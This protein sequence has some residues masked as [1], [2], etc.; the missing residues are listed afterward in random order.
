M[1]RAERRRK[2]KDDERL[3]KEG[4]DAQSSDPAGT[5]AMMRLMSELLEAA[6]HERN[7]DPP[8]R[9][10]H[11]KVDA[12]LHAMR[13]QR[14]DCKKGCAHC[15][16]VWVSATI[17]EV[18]FVAKGMRRRNDAIATERV[19][20]AH[21]ITGA[22]NFTTRQRL[23]QQ[24]PLLAD[25]LCSV[26][27]TRPVSCRF[28]ASTNV[29]ACLRVFRQSSGE[30][31]PTPLNNLK[32]RGAYEIALSLALKHVGLPHYYYELNAALSRALERDDAESAWLGG[33]D[34]FFD[35]TRDPHDVSTDAVS[36][37]MYKFAFG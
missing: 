26:Y 24:C 3:L 34:V 7:I 18:L 33:Q 5:A 2:S 14:V 1:N 27:E 6:K 22:H 8:V 13:A 37:Q 35:V 36:R 15:C 12:T 25:D 23:H 16:R 10:L 20:A 11:T 32:G 30:T 19:S 4:I 28:W 9:F 17:P 31:V 21:R 29:M